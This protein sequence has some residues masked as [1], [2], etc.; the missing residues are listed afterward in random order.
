VAATVAGQP[1][2]QAEVDARVVRDLDP[3]TKQQS[4]DNALNQLIDEKLIGL[5][6]AALKTTPEELLAREVTAKA[7]APTDAEMEAFY[8]QQKA[9]I[10]PN[11][12]KETV[13]PQIRG[14]L[15]AQKAEEV[16]KTYFGGLRAKYDVQNMILA[17]RTALEVEKAKAL[18][19][20]IESGAAPAKGPATAPVTIVEFSDFQCPFCARVTPTVDQAVA[21]Y[22]DKVRVLFR[23][24][25]LDIHADAQK[26][27]EAALCAHE[28]G[29]F[30]EMHDAMF[31]DQR[32]L[33]VEALKS[34][35][36]TLQ[37]DSAA[38]NSCLDAGK[39]AAA[40]QSDFD[41]GVAIGVNSTPS[42]YVNGRYLSGA[43]S[44]D[45]LARIIDEELKRAGAAS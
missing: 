9:R 19:P 25:P 28:Q 44:Y 32:A 4:I 38:F 27:A 45:V 20:R 39:A 33:G 16:R 18:R 10:P 6:A 21:K 7:A 2:T 41:M 37:L 43:V 30:W 31:A 15:Q 5:E 12:T 1:V 8:E 24:F 34:K 26:A 11:M 23:Q 42:I 3:R 13:M 17:E 29:K 36:V 40:V 22:G 35:A 14:Y